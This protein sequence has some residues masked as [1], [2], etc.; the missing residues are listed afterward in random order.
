MSGVSNSSIFVAYDD[1]KKNGINPNTLSRRECSGGFILQGCTGVTVCF[2]DQD[3]PQREVVIKVLKVWWAWKQSEE[4][5]Q[6]SVKTMSYHESKYV[7]GGNPNKVFDILKEA[8]EH[9]HEQ[10]YNKGICI[11]L[12]WTNLG[13]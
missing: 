10:V 1:L 7:Q 5:F 3:S 6:T 12:E 2:P 13:Y 4:T 9:Y 11:T 8:A